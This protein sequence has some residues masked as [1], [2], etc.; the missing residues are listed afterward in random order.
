MTVTIRL[1]KEEEA[2]L[3]GLARRTGRT[4]SFY[5]RAAI[6]EYLQDLEDAYAADEALRELTA[7]GGR[8]APLADLEAQ[9][10]ITG[11]DVTRATAELRAA[12]DL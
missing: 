2:R 8:G 5:V 11:G 1:T 3:D 10:G 12:G 6:R 4:K 9:L 7:A